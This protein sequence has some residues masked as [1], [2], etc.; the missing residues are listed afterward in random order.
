[1]RALN[2]KVNIESVN[3]AAID[4]LRVSV[5]AFVDPNSAPAPVPVAGVS[6]VIPTG[7]RRSRCPVSAAST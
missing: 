4:D 7:T 1:M 2:Q 3:S 6:S 5:V